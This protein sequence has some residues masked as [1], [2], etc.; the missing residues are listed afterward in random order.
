M[1][2]HVGVSEFRKAYLD[3]LKSSRL[4]Q[5]ENRSKLL[6]L[7]YATECGLKWL[8]MRDIYK[9]ARTESVLKKQLFWGHDLLEFAKEAKIGKNFFTG[10]SVFKIRDRNNPCTCS[11]KELHQ[12]WRYGKE[13]DPVDEQNASI[14]LKNICQWLSKK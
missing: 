2:V 1:S 6:L 9:I 14:M 11:L 12:V 8:L 3:H 4:T 5:N 10:G 13:L 7:F